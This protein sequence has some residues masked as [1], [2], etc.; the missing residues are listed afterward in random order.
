[1]KCN[2]LIK[3]VIL[4]TSFVFA[5]AVAQAAN[6]SKVYA[7]YGE[8]FYKD[9]KGGLSG[10]ALQI[11]LKGIL[12]SSHVVQDGTF[13]KIV[14]SC[15]GSGGRCYRHTA[16]GYGNARVWLMGN[17][18]LSED[19]NNA[20]KVKDVYCNKDKTNADFRGGNIPAPNRIPD[21]TVINVEHTWPQSH[22]TGKHPTDFQKSDL[23]H[24][25]PTDSELNA[26]RGNHKFGEVSRDLK[27]L[28]C[29]ESRFG[30][31]T[32]GNQE[33]FEPPTNHKGNVARAIFYFATRYDQYIDQDE[34]NVLRKWN[35]EDP[36]DE[37][38]VRRNDGIFQVQGNRNPFVDYPELSDLV[39]DF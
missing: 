29:R 17:F 1:M 4:I 36:V 25:F 13:D 30:I 8:Q 39:A 2:T 37:E 26:I 35:Q 14:S 3:T 31:G 18:Y 12:K 7:Y 32:A 20:Y 27:I 10:Q 34:E 19:G 38:E 6:Q 22:F 23:H 5:G 9:L 24:L 15:D 16:F 33:I 21:N 11:S 28:K